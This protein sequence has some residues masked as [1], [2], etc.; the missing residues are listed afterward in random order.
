MS[1][2]QFWAYLG[3]TAGIALL[4][5]AWLITQRSADP[6]PDARRQLF[7]VV[8]HLALKYWPGRTGGAA[9]MGPADG[10]RQLLCAGGPVGWSVTWLSLVFAL[11]RPR[12]CSASTPTS[13]RQTGRRGAYPAGDTRREP[14]RRCVVAMIAA[15][16]LLC[17]VL[18]ATG[19]FGWALLLVFANLPN[20]PLFAVFSAPSRRRGD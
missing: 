7:C 3:V 13:W 16:C 18:V 8:L 11:G 10:G 2:R 9:G 17:L 19:S 20:C 5:G 15:Q 14:V 6:G 4:L 1:E 12:Y